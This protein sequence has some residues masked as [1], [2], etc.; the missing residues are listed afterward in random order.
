MDFQ[1]KHFVVGIDL[2]TT[3]CAVSYVDLTS[4]SGSRDTSPDVSQVALQENSQD[5]SPGGT[6]GEKKIRTFKV[7]QLTG[8]GEFSAIS[9]LPSFLYIPGQY[10]VSD[11]ALKHPWKT[12][13]DRFVGTFARD[14]GSKLP[15]RLVSSAKSWLCHARADRESKILPWG[16]EG[17]DK[18]SPVTATALYLRHI[19]KAWNHGKK[20]EDLFLENQFVVIT[21]P[22]SFDEAAREFTLKAAREA[23]LGTNV[24]L[25]EE[26][27]AAF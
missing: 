19:K 23:G 1:D 16:A 7:P 13:D 21:V 17:I 5:E 22:A 26:P 20:D 4:L 25:L 27:L 15:S 8:S 10:D 3:N 18:V 2:G 11:N 14:H 6:V 24:T 9:V 12:E